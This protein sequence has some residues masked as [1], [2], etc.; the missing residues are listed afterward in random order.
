LAKIQNLVERY[1]IASLVLLPLVIEDTVVGSLSLNTVEPRHFFD[2]EIELAWSVAGQVAGALARTRLAETRRLLMVAIEQVPES[3]V[4]TDLEGTIVY[5]NPAFE[6]ITGYSRAEALG[7]NP[8]ILKSG[9]HDAAFYEEMWHTISTG[10]VWQGQ[11]VNRKKDGLIFAE[12]AIIAPVRDE[13]GAI[14]NYIAI[15]RDVTLELQLEEQYRQ[16]QRLE[17]IGQ[18]AGGVAHDF[19][20]ILT[21]ITGYSE[22]LLTQCLSPDNPC[23]EEVAEIQKAAERASI[24]TRQLLAFS[25]QQRLKPQLLNMNEVINNLEKMLR[26]LI[27]EDITL[28]TNL[29]PDLGQIK[30]D[31][32]Q[33]E[34]V[35]MNLAV[36]ARDAM[37]RGG[38]LILETT[39]VGSDQIQA[40]THLELTAN[41]YTK[42][43]VTDTGIGMDTETQARIFEP[44]FTTKE[45][46]KGT[47]LGL[48]TVYGIVQQSGGHIVVQS[49][50]GQGTIFTIFLPQALQKTELSSSDWVSA[51][52]LFG[53][54]T[55]LLVEDETSVSLIATKMLEARGYTVLATDGPETALTFC[56]QNKGRIDLLIADVI[57][58]G[59]SGIELA[60]RLSQLIPHLKVLFISGY[61]NEELDRYNVPAQDID[62]L[63]KPFSSDALVRKVR[64]ILDA[65]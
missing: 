39:N 65:A 19:N 50:P 16:A 26:R 52:T 14:V 23:R 17:S 3:V 33:M 24:L 57:M 47:G 1:S 27:G 6:Q 41:L 64:E 34:Q 61:S 7:Q 62:L 28:V 25:R 2:E 37:P 5:V 51:A 59:M 49:S 44:F 36:N 45:I 13:Q 18:L 11:L 9:R 60:E 12:E 22:L 63:E 15:K 35:L 54:E 53:R 29:A 21:V 30:T 56:R 4:T 38:Q 8:R 10:Q 58:P 20:N 32:G 40:A 43:T 55:I 31:P 42:L 48:A 46:G